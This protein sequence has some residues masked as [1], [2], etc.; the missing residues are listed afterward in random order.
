M[1]AGSQYYRYTRT[2]GSLGGKVD[3]GYPRPLSVWDGVPRTVDAVFQFQKD[4]NYQT[5]F[6]SDNEY[7]RFDDGQFEVS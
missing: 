6:F 3:S 7:Y 2:Q 1:I 5:Y 4:R